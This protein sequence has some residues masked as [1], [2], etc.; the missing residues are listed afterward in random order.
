M[1]APL[2]QEHHTAWSRAERPINW[3][4]FVLWV[5]AADEVGRGL[6]G[7]A[8]RGDEFL[9]RAPAEYVEPLSPY[10][11]AVLLERFRP[12]AGA[13]APSAFPKPPPKPDWLVPP[14]LRSIN[15][16][17]L[18]RDLSPERYAHE[19]EAY[20]TRF[21]E[22]TSGL[23]DEHR[24]E[25]ARIASALQSEFEACAQ[26]REGVMRAA[27]LR[28]ADGSVTAVLFHERT[29]EAQPVQAGYWRTEAG[30]AALWLS[31]I[32]KQHLYIIQADMERWFAELPHGHR[33]T[34]QPEPWHPV[35]NLSAWKRWIMSPVALEEAKRRASR[36]LDKKNLDQAMIDL[37]NSVAEPL[38]LKT[39]KPDSA[40]RAWR[41]AGFD[42]L[43][44]ADRSV[45]G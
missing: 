21:A 1:I 12:E 4:G 2:I 25:A 18:H 9:A 6:F 22:I 38:G 8:W 16:P 33:P 27:R 17:H 39:M 11:I 14:S 5:E 31:M 29:G 20:E 3:T 23:T 43:A 40:A 32:G 10:A 44:D 30:A 37:W 34:L 24:R 13:P 42:P 41:T 36:P 45:V 19:M 35:G 28:L 7:E 26:R 15:T